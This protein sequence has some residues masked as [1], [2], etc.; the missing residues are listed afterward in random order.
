[1]LQTS[2][3]HS[4]VLVPDVSD[5]EF[6]SLKLCGGINLYTCA[7]PAASIGIAIL[8]DSGLELCSQKYGLLVVVWFRCPSK[9]VTISA[10]VRLRSVGIYCKHSSTLC[11]TLTWSRFKLAVAALIWC[12]A[13]LN[14]SWMLNIDTPDSFSIF[15]CIFNSFARRLETARSRLRRSQYFCLSVSFLSHWKN[16]RCWC[17]F[18]VLIL[19]ASWYNGFFLYIIFIFCRRLSL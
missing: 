14:R 13:L 5:F 15:C 7:F 12:S 10:S 11:L 6:S 17:L 8:I 19:L 1:M 9:T 3:L 18:F 2:L 16:F 4:H